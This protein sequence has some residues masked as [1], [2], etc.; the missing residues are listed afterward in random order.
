MAI[1]AKRKIFNL[2]ALVLGRRRAFEVLNFF[3]AIFTSIRYYLEVLNLKHNPLTKRSQLLNKRDYETIKQKLII[4]LTQNKRSL[5]V[6]FLVS[7]SDKWSA[8]SIFDAMAGDE[9]FDP[10]IVV[11][12]RYIAD[13]SENKD[14]IEENYNFFQNKNMRVAKG[15]DEEADCYIDL[16]KFSP[17][18]IFYQQPWSIST[19]HFP[20]RTR[21]F[22]LTCYIPYGFGCMADKYYQN[23]K[24]NYFY[25]NLW[26]IF[27]ESK[28]HAKLYEKHNCLL[29]E[30]VV[31]AGYPKMDTYLDKKSP[32]AGKIWKI[33]RTTNPDI[34]RV[35]WAPHWS[36]MTPTAE[37]ATFDLNYKFFLEFARKNENIDWIVKPHPRLKRQCADC[38]LMCQEE[39]E[40]YFEQWNQLPN[41]QVYEGGDFW[42]IFKTS[43]GLIFDS[44][45]FLAE[46]MP[47]GKPM[48]FI[49]KPK[50]IAF[51]LFGNKLAEGVYRV[52]EWDQIVT[53]IDEVIIKGNDPLKTKR[54]S[55]IENVISLPGTKAG[56]NIKEYLR[57]ELSRN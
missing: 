11:T 22:A 50:K 13:E 25:R 41:G 48:F 44:I 18:I 10:L 40:E 34:K 20:D 32:D 43:D 52:R 55:I 14:L 49:D 56:E 42:D 29:P 26:K 47:T 15:Y 1:T 4:S 23:P 30:Q 8:Q 33:K 7:V 51:N 27:S 45:S 54:R 21:N 37:F 28:F 17:D 39:I 12:P 57:Q 16:R 9:A 53:C 3:W 2:A 31:V 35:I 36:V 38:N 46:Y 24:A 6:V 5:K 19:V